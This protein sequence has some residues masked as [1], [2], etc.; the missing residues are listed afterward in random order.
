[1]A[2]TILD[3][4]VIIVIL[5]SS[6]LAMLRGFSRELLSLIS[7]IVATVI[8]LFLFKPALPFVE[9]YLS[10]KMIALIVTLVIIFVIVLSIISIVTMKIA[11]LIIDSQIGM[12]DRT[13]G[14]IFGALR[15]LLIVVISMMLVNTLIKPE[16]QANW[17]KNAKTKPILDSLGLEIWDVLPK[18]LSYALE[19]IETFFKKDDVIT[20]IENSPLSN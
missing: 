2:I 1:M 13:I 15:G 11:D 8:T 9:Q 18:N 6:F 4:I 7:W 10:N 12:L 14:F 17:L 5:F 3:G 16:Q 20:D 19:K